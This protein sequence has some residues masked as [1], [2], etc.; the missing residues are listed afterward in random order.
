MQGYRAVYSFTDINTLSINQNPD[1][2]MPAMPS[3]NAEKKQTKKEFITFKL[4]KDTKTDLST[5][6]IINPQDSSGEKE[7]V[8]GEENPAAQGEM[9][10]EMME[11]FK[12]MFKDMRITVA[13]SVDGNVLKT[14]ASY[15]DGSTVTLIDMDFNKIIANEDAFKKLT[16]SDPQ[17][18]EQTKQLI[19]S[20]PG[21]KAELKDQVTVEFK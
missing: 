2:N 16:A 10:P 8:K 18:V 19:Q 5:L 4:Q 6:T 1:E 3:E 17:S 15:I 20:I 14:D 12:Q 21:I 13:V 7:D 9:S 11:M